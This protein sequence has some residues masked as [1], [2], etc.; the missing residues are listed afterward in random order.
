[1][2]FFLKLIV[3]FVNCII[4]IIFLILKNSLGV[5]YIVRDPR[6]VV[7]LF[8]THNSKSIENTADLLIDDLAVGNENNEVEVYTG[9]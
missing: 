3:A 4:S 1:M 2:L 7:I 9:S 6:N 8:A 5:I